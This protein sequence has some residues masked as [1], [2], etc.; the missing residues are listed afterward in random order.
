[1]MNL[2]VILEVFVCGIEISKHFL[3]AADISKVTS[4]GS[5]FHQELMGKH[6]YA[7]WLLYML[8]KDDWN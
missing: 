7:E 6:S 3:L 1:M 8:F 4:G 5:Y 2:M